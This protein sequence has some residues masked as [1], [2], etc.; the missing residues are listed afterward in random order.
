MRRLILAGMVISMLLFGA[1]SV[2]STPATAP[3]PTPVPDTMSSDE[4]VLLIV[5]RLQNL[6]ITPEAKE[7][8][9]MFSTEASCRVEY[10]DALQ[11]WV[12]GITP[13]QFGYD[14]VRR[15]SWFQVSDE[16]YFLDMHWSEPKPQWIVH[17]DGRIFPLGKGSLVEADIEELNVNRTLSTLTPTPAKPATNTFEILECPDEAYIGDFIV[18]SGRTTFKTRH[19]LRGRRGSEGIY[20]L[21]FR[22]ESY[23]DTENVVRWYV[24]IPEKTK[25][26]VISLEIRVPVESDRYKTVFS[27]NVTIKEPTSSVTSAPTPPRCFPITDSFTLSPFDKEAYDEWANANDSGFPSQLPFNKFGVYIN[28][29]FIEAEVSPLRP[30][31][32]DI[33]MRSDQPISIKMRNEF[34]GGVTLDIQH[35]VDKTSTVAG[36]NWYESCELERLGSNWEATIILKPDYKGIYYFSFTNDSGKSSWCQYTISLHTPSSTTKINTESELT[37]AVLDHLSFLATASDAKQFLTEFQ[38][39]IWDIAFLVFDSEGAG[40]R[41]DD[42]KDQDIHSYAVEFAFPEEATLHGVL[43]NEITAYPQWYPMYVKLCSW[44]VELDGTVKPYNHNAHRVETEL[45][46]STTLV[47]TYPELRQLG[48]SDEPDFFHETVP[49]EVLE[50]QEWDPIALEKK[51]TELA[52]E[53]EEAHPYVEPSHVCRHMAVELWKVLKDNNITSLIVVGNTENQEEWRI[54]RE[55]NHVW[56]VVLGRSNLNLG[57]EC[58]SSIVYSPSYMRYYELD[59]EQTYREYGPSSSQWETAKANYDLVYTRYEQHLEGYFYQ[60]PTAFYGSVIL[61]FLPSNW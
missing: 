27:R 7:Y 60:S 12:V 26:G 47:W 17:D 15:A 25:V 1:C 37:A 14:M 16:D 30:E 44:L 23:P 58:T 10:D 21:V 13:G 54:T 29:F 36:S 28:T 39:N 32:L 38:D 5:E 34:Y 40:H 45:T 24:Q 57:V 48:K 22:E 20:F 56:I 53:Y 3:E 11:E 43:G 9:T 51:V 18:V 33:V 2:P 50:N 52:K 19:E 61:W 6:A 49:R 35:L 46:P 8:V 4:A 59:C 55:C 41:I 31:T 42:Y